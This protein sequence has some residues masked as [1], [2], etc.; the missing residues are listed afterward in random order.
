M[1]LICINCYSN[2]KGTDY[3][4]SKNQIKSIIYVFCKELDLDEILM[5]ELVQQESSYVCNAYSKVGAQGLTQIMPSNHDYFIWKFKFKEKFDYL[6]DLYNI[7]KSDMSLQNPIY[8]LWWGCS[9]LKWIQNTYSDNIW[10][11]LVIYHDGQKWF[12][13][14]GRPTYVGQNYANTIYDNYLRRKKGE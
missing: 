9:Y 12:T 10:T 6:F 14:N 8:N 11:S 5:Q 3:K 2:T 13:S 4:L 7:P 1:S